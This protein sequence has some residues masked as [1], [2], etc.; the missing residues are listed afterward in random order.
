[1]ALFPNGPLVRGPRPESTRRF[2]L[3]DVVTPQSVDDPNWIVGGVNWEDFLCGNAVESFLDNCPTT[4]GFTK[5]ETRPLNFCHSD[6]F[7]IVESFDCS[8][9]GRVRR[10]TAGEAFE[11]ARQRLLNW[12]EWELERVFWTGLSNNGLVNPSL[13]VGND[14]CGLAPVDLTPGGGPLNP[15]AA[16][17]TLEDA[18]ADVFPNGGVIHVPYGLA[19]YLE[20]FRLMD[21]VGDRMYTPTG[22]AY[23]LGA[24]YPGSG[25]LNVPA[26]PGE[27]WIF[28][29]GPVAVWRSDLYQVPNELSQSIDRSINDITVYAERYY[30]VGFSCGVFA[31]NVTLSCDCA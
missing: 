9:G 20:N 2:G 18:M 4:T 22:N 17:A 25:P 10:Y 29:T 13:A 12:E 23:V 27:T 7:N 15:V 8:V 14:E 6:P 11:I 1:M 5:P 24:G 31:L 28:A 16:I 3:L 30:A 26:D 19:A 21:Q